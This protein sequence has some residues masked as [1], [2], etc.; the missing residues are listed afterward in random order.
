[1]DRRTFV[2]AGTATVLGSRLGG[3]VGGRASRRRDARSSRRRDA[4]DRFAREGYAPLGEVAVE[5][6][7]EA[8]GDQWEFYVEPEPVPEDRV[9]GLAGGEEIDLGDRTLAVVEAPGHAS[10]QV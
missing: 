8:V 5:G 4:G 9:D 1:M 7:K 10:H 6:T 2:A 3:V